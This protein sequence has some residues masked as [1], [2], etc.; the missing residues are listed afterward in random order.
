MS[1]TTEPGFAQH[2]PGHAPDD[3]DM[4]PPLEP[5]RPALFERR[6]VL[7]FAVAATLFPPILLATFAGIAVSEIWAQ[8]PESD[9]L[10]FADGGGGIL[11]TVR[12][13]LSFWRGAG[14]ALVPTAGLLAFGS[15]FVWSAVLDA[16]RHDEPLRPRDVAAASV[17]H[18]GRL[19]AVYG[20]FLVLRAALV[21]IT[22]YLIQAV[23]PAIARDGS[24]R[25]QT[26]TA[27]GAGLV[28]LGLLELVRI[29]HDLAS[30]VVVRHEAGLWTTLL[31]ALGAF[32]EGFFR[33]CA[34]RL[35]Y[36]VAALGLLASTSL[37][38]SAMWESK[39]ALLGRAVLHA[40]ALGGVVLLRAA[41]LHGLF[42]HVDRPPLTTQVDEPSDL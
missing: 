5:R 11:E 26:L 18:V 6:G 13:S 42:A 17:V 20:I 19:A 7:G 37:A 14:T 39:P 15:L 35:P 31:T 2:P 9:R 33:L 8:H 12:L 3:A 4:A 24:E 30:V 40:A 28:G 29:V 27:I 16:F 21:G 32:R 38:A 41:W 34:R 22:V 1:Q 23:A 36:L 25:A 10:L